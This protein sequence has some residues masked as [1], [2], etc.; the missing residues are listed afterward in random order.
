MNVMNKKPLFV[1]ISDIAMVIIAIFVV[2]AFFKG[3][4]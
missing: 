1:P 4:G 3:W 2:L